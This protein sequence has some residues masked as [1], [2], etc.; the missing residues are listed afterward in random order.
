M[1]L[2]DLVVAPCTRRGH[3]LPTHSSLKTSLSLVRLA[4]LLPHVFLGSLLTLDH[5]LLCLL[6]APLV[7]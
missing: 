3:C 2:R 4:P 7:E 1:K 5:M 6:F